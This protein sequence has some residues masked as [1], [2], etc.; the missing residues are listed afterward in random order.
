MLYVPSMNINV[1]VGEHS[2]TTYYIDYKCMYIRVLYGVT[3]QRNEP[4]AQ[5]RNEG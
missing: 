5:N 1:V 3:L 4:N 2:V